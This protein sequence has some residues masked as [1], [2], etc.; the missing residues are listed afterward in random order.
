MLSAINFMKYLSMSHTKYAVKYQVHPSIHAM[1]FKLWSIWSIKEI[2]ISKEVIECKS[3]SRS[4]WMITK[5]HTQKEHLNEYFEK[6]FKKNFKVLNK[7]FKKLIQSNSQGST[8]EITSMS[9]LRSIFM[10]K[11]STELELLIDN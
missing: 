4:I 5:K 3:K 9:L 10:L 11:A 7:H 1:L 6:L 2:K 8:F